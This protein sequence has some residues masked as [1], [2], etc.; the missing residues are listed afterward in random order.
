M[1]P[2][3]VYIRIANNFPTWIGLQ[4]DK[5]VLVGISRIYDIGYKIIDNDI[6]NIVTFINGE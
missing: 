2:I 3:L 6:G 5:V 4:W 1:T